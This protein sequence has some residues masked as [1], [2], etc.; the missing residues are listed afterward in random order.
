[1]K[2]ATGVLAVLLMSSC[3]SLAQT[4]AVQPTTPDSSASA[5]PA[6]A[7]APGAK[8]FLEPM[9]GFDQLLADS[10]VHKKVPVVVVKDRGEADFVLSGGAHVHNRNFITGMVLSS[11]GGANIVMKD[12][13]SGNLVFA[14]NFHR[15]DS[16]ERDGDIYLGWADQCAGHLKKA[17]KKK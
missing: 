3:T 17:L 10:I 15:V 1:M 13:H 12:A 11:R 14:C 2:T 5:V 4:A 7:F 8:V 6:A 9:D 16:N